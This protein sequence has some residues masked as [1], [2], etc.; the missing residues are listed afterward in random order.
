MF[1]HEFKKMIR[2]WVCAV[3][4]LFQP[5]LNF[6]WTHVFQC[7]N[8]LHLMVIPLKWQ[9][10]RIIMLSQVSQSYLHCPVSFLS[11]KS[12]CFERQAVHWQKDLHRG[13]RPKLVF[14]QECALCLKAINPTAQSKLP[15]WPSAT[16]TPENLLQLS[17]LQLSCLI[18]M[19]CSKSRIKPLKHHFCSNVV[20][21]SFSLSTT[22]KLNPRW[23]VWF[24]SITTLTSGVCQEGHL[25]WI[26]SLP[27]HLCLSVKADSWKS[28]LKV[29][30]H[31][32]VIFNYHLMFINSCK[33]HEK[34]V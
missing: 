22:S 8:R 27:N 19:M 18:A 26:N 17:D 30:Q 3:F 28:L 31:Q 16:A 23:L 5:A 13:M 33:S 20:N 7:L 21:F 12:T 11:T 25:M 4:V 24:G 9:T 29:E 1:A 34:Q 6:L 15:P 32:W 10:R 14:P 2:K